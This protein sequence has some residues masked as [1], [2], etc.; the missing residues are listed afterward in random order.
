MVYTIFT[1]VYMRYIVEDMK[2]E[3]E[4]EFMKVNRFHMRKN[5][6]KIFFENILADGH[7]HQ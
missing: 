5:G 4:C 7:K 2:E 6:K 1:H 3:K